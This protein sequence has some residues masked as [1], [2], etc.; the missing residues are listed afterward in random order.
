MSEDGDSGPAAVVVVA[1]TVGVDVQLAASWYESSHAQRQ[2][3][4]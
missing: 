3:Q 1:G 2:G 4:R